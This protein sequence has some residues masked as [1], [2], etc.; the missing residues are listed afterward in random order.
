MKNRMVRNDPQSDL[1]RQVI[2]LAM[3]VHRTLG[4]GFAESIYRNALAIELR[5]ADIIFELHPTLSVTYE[6][7]EVGV[8]QA[9]IIINRELIVE[10]K[11]A[12]ALN[13]AH[14]AQLV[15]Y[16]AATKIDQGLLLN[17]GA[18]SLEFKTKTRLYSVPNEPPDLHL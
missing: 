16:L 15:N 9:D 8:F 1:A 17:F 6:G 12:D 13:P 11:V 5:Q 7:A 14:S 18:G 4:C 2:G 10:L 3:K